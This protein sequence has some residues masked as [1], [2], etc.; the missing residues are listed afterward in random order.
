MPAAP[1]P[2]ALPP[3]PTGPW[4]LWANRTVTPEGRVRLSH[5]GSQGWVKL[6]FKDEPIVPVEVIEDPEGPFWGWLDSEH[7][8]ERPTLIWE[9][10]V[11]FDMCFSS[12]PIAARE[13][14]ESR[15]GWARI[16]RLR[17]QEVAVP[18]SS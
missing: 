3:I 18:P 11:L 9:G 12:G 10:K 5:I 1:T 17:V 16:V 4:S 13:G 15:N 14:V 8:A 7:N 2:K 6:H